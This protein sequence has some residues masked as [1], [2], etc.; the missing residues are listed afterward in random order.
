MNKTSKELDF[1][2]VITQVSKDD[3]PH[4]SVPL[5]TTVIPTPPVATAAT[6]AAATTNGTKSKGRFP[7]DQ[8]ATFAF[9]SAKVVMPPVENVG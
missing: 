3:D 7:C 1:S 6:S 4:R 9:V 2:S 5:T 8:I